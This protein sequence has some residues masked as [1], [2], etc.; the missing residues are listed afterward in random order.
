MD[1]N[2]EGLVFGLDIGTRSI[3]GTVGYRVGRDGFIVSAMESVEHTTRAV[4]DGQIHDISAVTKTIAEIKNR[5]ERRLQCELTE[6]SI[7][8]AGRVLKT[9]QV[10][11]VMEFPTETKVTDDHI[12]SLDMLGI[13][14][15]YGEIRK[16]TSKDEKK[17][18]C[19][20]YSP[21]KYYLNG[22][23][24]EMLT[25]HSANNI[26]V[27]LIA[28]FLPDEVVD[29]LYASVE[30][31]G[32]HV[33]SLTLEP[34]AAIQ[35]AIPDKFRLLNIALVDVG[36][37][38]SDISIVKDGSII[39]FGMI[40]LAGDEVTEAIARHYLID[41]ETAERIKRQCERR[42]SVS[43]KN[44]FG[45]SVRVDREEIARIS[46]DAVESITKNIAEH[47]IKLNGDKSVSAVF[48]VGGGGK[49][50]TFTERLAEHLHLPENRVALRGSEV[51]TN[52]RFEQQ[53]IQ[54]DSTLVTP[55]GI[56][57]NYYEQKNNFVHVVVNDQG[58][59]LYD[60]G[61]A[62]VLDACISSGFSQ[63]NLFPIRGDELHFSVNGEERVVKGKS[64]EVAVIKKNGK[65]VSLNEPVEEHDII[66][67]RPS[68][69]GEKGK[70]SLGD[71]R[72]SKEELEVLVFGKAIICPKMV[73][74]NGNLASS[75]YDIKDK[76]RIEF[77]DYYPVSGV[78]EFAG[79]EKEDLVLLN[80]REAGLAAKVYN[81]D[82]IER[83]PVPV[84]QKEEEPEETEEERFEKQME[85]DPLL[86]PVKP[87]PDWLKGIPFD[88]AKLDS[89]GN[90]IPGVLAQTQ[91][92]QTPVRN[93]VPKSLEVFV[94]GD[95][96]TIPNKEKPIFV[97]VLDVFPFDLTKTGGTRLITKI[98]GIDRDFTEPLSDG[99]EIEIYWE[100]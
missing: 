62:T 60:N 6:V 31:V 27:D 53:G 48:V 66:T 41:F 30:G 83:K 84:S 82:V 73:E 3:V 14:Q 68:T 100:N 87:L 74:V 9:K 11:T 45:E 23:P 47:I 44:I 97:D 91:K 36:A 61:K 21:K 25:L 18:Y 39:A 24:M 40:P 59:K 79:F 90:V 58:V 98:N 88:T 72:E 33:A 5:L 77:F 51:L 92:T 85:K 13:E 37:G 65:E 70:M 76:D 69:K 56:C 34:I 28:T 80:G 16:E 26:G 1:T 54:K 95:V 46:A 4:I 20:G 32:L 67:I 2:N 71:L 42:K 86:Q 15:A 8:A 99:D 19:V 63:N 55:I 57:M 93:V 22:Y 49:H 94:N 29:G 64:G 12:R 78:L 10:H 96:Y 52:V 75:L 17:F 81:G 38:T 43:F 50:D 7:A 89:E 35:V